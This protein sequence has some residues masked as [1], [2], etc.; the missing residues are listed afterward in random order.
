MG[1]FVEGMGKFGRGI[2]GATF[3][4]NYNIKNFNE[5][6]SYCTTSYI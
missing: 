6:K 2:K 4:D 1:N 3:N 5:Q